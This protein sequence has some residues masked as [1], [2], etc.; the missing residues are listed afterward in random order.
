MSAALVDAA[1]RD[2]LETEA[3]KGKSG[4]RESGRASDLDGEGL[5]LEER[6]RRTYGEAP[7]EAGG[8]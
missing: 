2:S 6:G 4:R 1:G 7:R 3:G 8:E 5:D